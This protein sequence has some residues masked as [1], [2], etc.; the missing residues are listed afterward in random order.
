MARYHKLACKNAIHVTEDIMTVGEAAAILM[1]MKLADH[2]I[3]PINR[4]DVPRQPT[5]PPNTLLTPL[6]EGKPPPEKLRPTANSAEPEN[7][8]FHPNR[9]RPLPKSRTPTAM[10]ERAAR[11]WF[12]RN[13][14][15]D[16]TAPSAKDESPRR[17]PNDDRMDVDST[18]QKRDQ[19]NTHSNGMV[20]RTSD[21][22]GAGLANQNQAGAIKIEEGSKPKWR[23]CSY[24]GVPGHPIAKCPMVPCRRCHTV[25][26]APKNCPLIPCK[27]CNTT[28]QHGIGNCPVVLAKRARDE[29]LRNIKIA[30]RASAAATTTTKK[31]PTQLQEEKTSLK[32]GLVAD[33]KEEGEEEEEEYA[34][35][36]VSIN[37]Q[38]GLAKEMRMQS[39]ICDQ[40]SRQHLHLHRTRTRSNLPCGY[41]HATGHLTKHCPVAKA[42]KNEWERASSVPQRKKR[43]TS[44]SRVEF[45]EQMN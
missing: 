29:Q 24:C 35:E 17:T 30:A 42:D 36:F 28:G 23:L 26:H 18:T 27:Y 8:G 10:D 44:E 22:A 3:N 15:I 45:K 16:T 11:D 2:L 19:V 20:S 37:S 34:N 14:D 5:L 9:P 43:Y 25:G 33:D 41:C 38:R 4:P 40:P 21:R 1:H 7:L 13:M 39:S 31:K 6:V 12:A 32:R